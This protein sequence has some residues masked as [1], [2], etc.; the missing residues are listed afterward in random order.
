MD[1]SPEFESPSL[2]SSLR[3]RRT[4]TQSIQGSEA[5][6]PK[7]WTVVLRTLLAYCVI[8]SLT[9][10]M[11]GRS[12]YMIHPWV[13]ADYLALGMVAPWLPLPLVGICYFLLF[14]NE[15]IGHLAPVYHF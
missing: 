6:P 7:A 12:I 10:T 1:P 5:T 2:N 14:V 9:F 13:N 11:L 8:P 3:R 15:L 4:S